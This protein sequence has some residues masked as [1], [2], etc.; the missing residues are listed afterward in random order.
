MGGNGVGVGE[1]D[2]TEGKGQG[3]ERGGQEKGKWNGKGLTRILAPARAS[4]NV[5]NGVAA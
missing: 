1:E 3:R 4:W 2:G 5:P